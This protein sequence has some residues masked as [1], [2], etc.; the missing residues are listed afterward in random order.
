[1][2]KIRLGA[3]PETEVKIPHPFA[4]VEQTGELV[5]GLHSPHSAKMV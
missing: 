1:M 4:Q 3:L 2:L 5:M